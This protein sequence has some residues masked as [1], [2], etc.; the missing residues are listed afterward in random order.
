M[1]DPFSYDPADWFWIVAGDETR[2]WSSAA[3]A[4]VAAPVRAFLDAGGL[5]T[6]IAGEAEL[7]D[8]LRPHGLTVPLPAGDDVRAEAE[9]RLMALV[10]ARDRRH[11]DIVMANGVREATRLLRKGEAIWTAEEAARAAALAGYDDTIET[12]RVASNAM[13]ADPPADFDDDR[14][15][16]AVP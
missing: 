3:G 13:E 12:I 4:Y 5:P 9:R 6:R 10:G 15:W 16:P 1:P 14:H 8:V 2:W 7:A 11:L